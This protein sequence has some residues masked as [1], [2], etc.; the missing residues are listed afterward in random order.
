MWLEK[1]KGGYRVY[2]K[3]WGGFEFIVLWYLVFKLIG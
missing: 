3:L 1:M 2:I